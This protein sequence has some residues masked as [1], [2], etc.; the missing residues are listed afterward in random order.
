MIGTSVAMFF[1]RRAIGMMS[2]QNRL[3]GSPKFFLAL[4]KRDFKCRTRDNGD[5]G[6]GSSWSPVKID[7]AHEDRREGGEQKGSETTRPDKAH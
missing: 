5:S 6:R 1:G 3:K 2:V 7:G 4:G